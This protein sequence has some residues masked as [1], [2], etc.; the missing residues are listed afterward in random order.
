MLSNRI[1]DVFVTGHVH[2]VRVSN[3]RN[4]TNINCGCW[5]SQSE[6]EEKRGIVP[7]PAKVPVLNLMTR[8]VR[9]MNF[10]GGEDG[11]GE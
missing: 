8:K 7:E 5:T 10:F 2:R 1:P 6:N 9:V 11:R 4:V 3:Y